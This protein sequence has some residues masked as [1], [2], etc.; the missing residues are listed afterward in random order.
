MKLSNTILKQIITYE[1]FTEPVR[2]S[3]CLTDIIVKMMSLGPRG[4]LYVIL[5]PSRSV[6]RYLFRVNLHL[7]HMKVSDSSLFLYPP[8][9]TQV[10]S[11]L[12]VLLSVTKDLNAN[13]KGYLPIH[14]VCQLLKSRAFS[15]HNVSIAEWITAQVC[16]N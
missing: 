4:P 11:Q 6:V 10:I 1:V 5:C 13:I 14:C 15:K 9:S 16:N 7:P 3:S 8:I 2:I 12:T